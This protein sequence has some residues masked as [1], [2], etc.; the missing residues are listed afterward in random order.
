MTRDLII[1][2][3]DLRKTYR[4]GHLRVEALRG[5]DFAVNRGEMVAIMGASGSGKTT[6]MNCLS[7]MDEFDGGEVHIGGKSLRDMSDNER[8]EYRATRM[9]FIFQVYNLLPVLSA[10]ENVE[11]PLLVS[12]VRPREARRRSTAALAQ[13]GLADRVNH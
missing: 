8:T 5:V 12:G 9:G 6:L 10:A 13:V 4:T 11:L 1:E 3:T 2:A 7:G